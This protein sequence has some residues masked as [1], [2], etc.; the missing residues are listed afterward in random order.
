MIYTWPDSPLSLPADILAPNG[1]K[2]SP[3]T[4]MTEKIDMIPS[5]FPANQWLRVSIRWDV[6]Q[7]M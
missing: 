2:P 7:V 1:A 4:M 5:N 6:P 3:G